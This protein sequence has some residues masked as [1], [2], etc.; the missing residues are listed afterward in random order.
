MIAVVA[1]M[2]EELGVLLEKLEDTQEESIPFRHF[3]GRMEGKDIVLAVCLTG[4]VNMALCAQYLLDHYPIT[5]MVNIGTA[6][7]LS[8]QLKIG[9]VVVG[10][11]CVQHDMDVSAFGYARG[12]VPDINVCRFICDEPLNAQLRR[13][14]FDEFQV[15]FGTILTGD[16]VVG[17]GKRKEELLRFFDGMVAEMEGAA[18]GQVCYVNHVPFTVIRAASDN[19]NEEA[20]G[21]FSV[22]IALASAHASLV[23]LHAIALISV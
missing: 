5:H 1:S 14:V 22:N 15:Y 19:A 20:E 11:D 13:L 10:R 17:D 16:C 9:D 18:M 21:D 4:K 12:L 7:A 6:G 3:V 8:A 2:V 23:A